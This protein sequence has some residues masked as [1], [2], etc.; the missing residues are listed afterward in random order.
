[1]DVSVRSGRIVGRLR[2]PGSKYVAQRAIV[3]ASH[4]GGTVTNVP[5]NDDVDRLCDG[6]RRL[7]YRVDEGPGERR[8]G[9]SP[10]ASDAQLDLGD[11][12][13]GARFL[14]A[15]AAL[16]EARTVIDGS[17]RLRERPMRP[18]CEALR[19]L[20][21][22]VEGNRLPVALRGPM[23]GREVFV[24]SDG[25]SPFASALILLVDRVPGLRVQVSGRESLSFV[26]LT[27]HV[28][29]TFQDPYPVEADY[30]AAA[31]FAAAAA[32]TD[33]DLL[34]EDL[35]WTSPQPDARVLWIL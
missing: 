20:G 19:R 25:S 9:G 17:P 4:R 23:R 33:G 31:P 30:G 35:A 16:R 12:A 5:E 29:R 13:T 10:A 28:H 27:A 15:L 18:L 24:E 34:V 8:I 1:M 26:G 3:L 21:V 6:L 32:A 14:M 11:N 7:G 22:R 2:P